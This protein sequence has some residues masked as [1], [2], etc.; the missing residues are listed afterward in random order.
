MAYLLLIHEAP[1]QREARTEA[2][3]R[4]AY[5]VMLQ[6]AQRLQQQGQ[7]KAVE[8]L[9]HPRAGAT[10]QVRQGKAS[11]LDGPFAEA[12]EFVGGFFLL[13]VATREAA[14]AIAAQ[15][16]AAQWATV[17]VRETGPCFL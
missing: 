9:T 4:A 13:D 5:E 15:C 1:G 17:E 2:E 10:V 8:S 7:L 3:G 11:V 14:L 12:K 16:P 6:F